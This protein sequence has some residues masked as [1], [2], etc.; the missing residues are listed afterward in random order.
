[1]EDGDTGHC[2]DSDSGTDGTRH[3]LVHKVRSKVEGGKHEKGSS[4][5]MTLLHIS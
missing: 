5:T 4:K 3:S 1:M 2:I